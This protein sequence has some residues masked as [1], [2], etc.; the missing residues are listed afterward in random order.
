[1]SGEG[2]RSRRFLV[3][4]GGS[5]GLDTSLWMVPYADLM[6]NM[7]I[8]F[9]ALFAYSYAD[10]RS[11]EYEKAVAQI[12]KEMAP[13]K[14][15]SEADAK[16]R[17][18]EL[19][20]RMKEEMQRLELDDFGIRVTARYV[21]LTLPT[22]VLFDLG[23]DRL[24][25]DAA[26]VLAPLAKLFAEAPNPVLVGGHTDPVPIVG[27]RLRTNWELSAARSFSVIEF[28]V[29]QGLAPERFLARG[30]GEYRPVAP[31]DTE[32]GR[33]R[34]RRIEIRLVREVRKS[35]G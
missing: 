2:S 25:P 23:S 8:L 13:A 14:T 32:Q 21:H 11:P 9:L 18:A 1:V 27:G 20:M 15:Q 6:S 26:R 10:N 29:G 33:R 30:Y 24:S 4:L 12:E 19:A 31:N 7:V 35:A 16:L 22:P 28:F 3:Q 17:E 34:N 5:E